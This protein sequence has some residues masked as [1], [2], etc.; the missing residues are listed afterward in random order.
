MVIIET[1]IFMIMQ[2]SSSDLEAALKVS[3]YLN[4]AL[5]SVPILLLLNR[6]AH[7]YGKFSF[8]LKAAQMHKHSC[9]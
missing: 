2:L 3:N 8:F 7:S 4:D 9:R 5:A 6:L 1:D